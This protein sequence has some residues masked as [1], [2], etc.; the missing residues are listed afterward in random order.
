M[1]VTKLAVAGGALIGLALSLSPQ[2]P[3]RL[4]RQ[5]PLVLKSVAHG[6]SIPVRDMPTTKGGGPIRVIPI[7]RRPGPPLKGLA[8]GQ[9]DPALQREKPRQ[10]A[11][12]IGAGV[13]LFPGLNFEGVG[14]GLGFM[15]SVPPPDAN[16]AV[17]KTQYVQWVNTSFAVFDKNT[18]NLLK[19]PVAGNTLW[20]SLITTPLCAADNNGD[21]VV[22]YDKLADR[23]VLSQFAGL[24]LLPNSPP[25]AICIA[26]S[27]T[28]DATG[29]F[30]MYEFDFQEFPDYPKMGVWPDAYYMSAN[31]FADGTSNIFKTARVCAFPRTAMLAGSPSATGLCFDD[32]NS[33]LIGDNG[34][35]PPSDF[36]LLPSDLD[37]TN[38]PPTGTPNFLVEAGP[39]LNV[40][41]MWKFHVDFTTP[42]NSTFSGPTVIPVS[43]FTQACPSNFSH[44]VPQPGTTQLLDSLSE[45]AM[46]R[47]AYRNFGAHE[48][49]V[50]N[51]TVDPGISGVPA[52]VRWYEIQDPNGTP[53]VVQQSTFSPDS[54]SRWMGSVALDHQSDL[55]I[56]YS[57][58]S[59]TLHPSINI[60]A[61]SASDP[62][63]QL[64]TE[65]VLQAGSGSQVPDACGTVN[66]C[67][68]R[69]GDYSDLTVDPVDDCTLWYTNEFYSVDS[70][71]S[72]H[73]RIGN[74]QLA[75]CPAGVAPASLPFAGQVVGTTSG[76]QSATITNSSTA[77]LAVSGVTVSGDFSQMSTCT[78]SVPANS[79]CTITIT[80]TPT[81]S[82]N[83]TGTLMIT[84]NAFSSPQT[85][86]LLGI[87]EDFA[88]SGAPSSTTVTAGQPATYTVAVGPQGGRGG[89]FPNAVS[90]T[91]S[92]VPSLS[93][94]SLNP[95]SV[96]LGAGPVTSTLT[97]TTT[98]PVFGLVP[99]ISGVGTRTLWVGVLL[100]AMLGIAIAKSRKLA[101]A[102][103][104]AVLAVLFV[105][106]G[107]CGGGGATGPRLISPGT[108]SGTF[109]ITVTG[110]S[111]SLQHSTNVTL[112]V[113]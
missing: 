93:S 80:F 51:H 111:G 95:P 10:Q 85:V 8:P 37:G 103:P 52:A 77:P 105:S 65:V 6:V 73:T 47:L 40:L 53:T 87:G 94:C 75:N 4:E 30:N 102:V 68:E 57:I 91:C 17:G 54:D 83:R 72:W 19:G 66:P 62:T 90:L 96:T 28:A 89:I 82:G 101:F 27:T 21:P 100:F 41:T 18:G 7:G 108:P 20:Q 12:G 33:G 48:S 35:L 70:T 46:F 74:F 64:S 88:V 99:P 3:Q 76:A 81:A 112:T 16:G 13:S 106:Q 60:A 9:T 113:Q 56:G 67:G 69:W 84:D 32:L 5:Q 1:S 55:A 109:P 31:V 26:L 97:I 110:T 42:A 104:V 38:P 45:R 58:S 59:S 107:G 25:F 24:S 44:C 15:P 49:L 98:A 50:V 29:T 22:Q 61:R 23:W 63:S 14:V 39:G 43:P 92:G 2:Q 36:S 11:A 79:T 71:S 34:G 78:P 86:P